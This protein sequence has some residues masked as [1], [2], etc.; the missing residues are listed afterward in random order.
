MPIV[1]RAL[2]DMLTL[3]PFTDILVNP[4]NM[5]GVAGKGLALA[6]RQAYPGWYDKYRSACERGDLQVGTLH[7]YRDALHP[8]PTIVSLVTKR[9]WVDESLL[10]DVEAGC[11]RLATYLKAH[12]YHTVALPILGSGLGRLSPDAVLPVM[13]R[14]LDALPN[15]IHLCQR[16]EAFP[17]PL[18]YLA[19]VGSRAYDDFDRI[20]LG[21]GETLLDFKLIYS[22]FQ[23]MVSGGAKGVD[24]VA[25]GRHHQDTT[26]YTLA[27]SHGLPAII[28]QADWDRY[29]KTAGFLRN[30]VVMDIATHIVAFVGHRSNDTR[31]MIDLIRKYNDKVADHTKASVTNPQHH[32]PFL[33]P[34]PPALVPK[35]LA[36]IDI[37]HL[38]P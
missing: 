10:E 28:C 34:P 6:F 18:R 9:H 1:R 31:N 38:V 33:T 19:V 21:V 13:Y 35:D 12:P 15:I 16:P 36:I 30:R 3:A 14:H 32:D 24:A 7:I 17:H 26:T 20:D 27:K 8:T 2:V 11:A 4:V 25:C 29:P 5:I 22:D 37:S 23:A